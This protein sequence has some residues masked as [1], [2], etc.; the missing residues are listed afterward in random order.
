[1]EQLA[2]FVALVGQEAAQLANVLVG[3]CDVERPEVLV[4]GFVH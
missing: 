2:V 3:V 4:E 1:V